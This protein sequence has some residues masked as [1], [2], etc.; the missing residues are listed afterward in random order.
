MGEAIEL[1]P[2]Y[3]AAIPQD[4]ASGVN[5]SPTP[6]PRRHRRAPSTG[7]VRQQYGAIEVLDGERILKLAGDGALT[8]GIC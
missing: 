3:V 1:T 4:G 2:H 6:L 7:L 5:P 8:G